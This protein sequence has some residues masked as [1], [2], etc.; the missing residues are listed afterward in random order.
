M[1]GCWDTQDERNMREIDVVDAENKYCSQ[2][3]V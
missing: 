1:G 3:M 2:D